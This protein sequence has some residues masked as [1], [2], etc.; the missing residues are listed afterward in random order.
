MRVE[1]GSCMG[2]EVEVC[3]VVRDV[4]ECIEGRLVK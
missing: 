4:R 3:V 1:G 2:G